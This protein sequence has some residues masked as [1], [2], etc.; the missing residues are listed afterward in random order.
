MHSGEQDLWLITLSVQQLDISG[1]ASG[2]LFEQHFEPNSDAEPHK[3]RSVWLLVKKN[4]KEMTDGVGLYG[5][6]PTS[7]F[8]DEEFSIA[9]KQ[10]A[11]GRQ[12]NFEQT[13]SHTVIRYITT[14]TQSFGRLRE[15]LIEQVAVLIAQLDRGLYS[16]TFQEFHKAMEEDDTAAWLAFSVLKP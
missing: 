2:I 5:S 13:Q 4:M 15:N 8:V 7:R 3:G 14:D 12:Y 9:A 10:E 16:K 6:C 1:L 11:G